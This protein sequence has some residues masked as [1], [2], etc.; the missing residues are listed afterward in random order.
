MAISK[1]R[2]FEL[3]CT[4]FGLGYSPVAPG[5]VGSLPAVGIF[6]LIGMLAPRH[7]HAALIAVALLC[8]CFLTVFLGNWAE[9]NW[10]KIDPRCFVLDEYAGFFLTV[11]VF[12]VDSVLA[13][14]VWGFVLTRIADII[15]PPP[16]NRLEEMPGG[17]G[18]LLD[19][20]A[21][22]LWAGIILI[23]L[24]ALFPSLFAF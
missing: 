13:T 7:Y 18:M 23:L 20:L 16:A 24:A 19:D 8:S 6:V 11:L 4:S 2:V 9:K 1:E 3:A 17:W 10:N 5:S 22:S 14:V 15:K 21:A 12:R